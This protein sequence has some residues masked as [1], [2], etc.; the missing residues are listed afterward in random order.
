MLLSIDTMYADLEIAS[1]DEEREDAIREAFPNQVQLRQAM[2]AL[3]ELLDP[4]IN[5]K[6]PLIRDA[7]VDSLIKIVMFEERRRR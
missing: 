5:T 6:D 2:L 4:T 1:S 7:E 3:I